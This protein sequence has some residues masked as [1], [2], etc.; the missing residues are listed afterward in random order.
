MSKIVD[1]IARRCGLFQPP[2]CADDCKM[3]LSDCE[4]VVIKIND[5]VR[6]TAWYLPVD[7]PSTYV[8]SMHGNGDCICNWAIHADALRRRY[9]ATVLIY[10]YRGYGKSGGKC[11]LSKLVPDGETIVRWLCRRERCKASDIIMHGYSLGGAVTVQLAARFKSK[12]LVV[13]SSFA[14][15]GAMARPYGLCAC[16]ANFIEARLVNYLNSTTAIERYHGVFLQCHGDA[17]TT[18]SYESGRELFNACPSKNKTFVTLR[19]CDHNYEYSRNYL[20]KQ[21]Q[22]FTLLSQNK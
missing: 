1:A 16:G 21:K 13:E 10:D 2:D 5:N 22:F 11:S 20:Q 8:I 15:L 18:I 17:D 9:N 14:S 7:Q 12:G 3:W 4:E 19:D 6:I